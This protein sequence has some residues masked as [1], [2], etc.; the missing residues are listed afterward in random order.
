LK[1][2]SLK[3]KCARLEKMLTEEYEHKQIAETLRN[4][5]ARLRQQAAAD[6]NR[7]F[8]DRLDSTTRELKSV[9]NGFSND[10]RKHREFVARREAGIP[11]YFRR[12][13]RYL[14]RFEAKTD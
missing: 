10:L 4:E 2:E 6:S 13:F 14:S 11:G 3:E 8:L 7:Q 9:V 5:M 12:L 1:K